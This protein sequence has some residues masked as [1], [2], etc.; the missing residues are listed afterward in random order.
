MERFKGEA[1]RLTAS[2]RQLK[3]T[4]EIR[5]FNL[6]ARGV[7]SAAKREPVLKLTQPAGRR[8]SNIGSMR[9]RNLG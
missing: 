7:L 5:Q 9:I 8:E 4:L 2:K 6:A 1:A 3:N